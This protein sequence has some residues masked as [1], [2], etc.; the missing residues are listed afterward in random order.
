MKYSK[1]M[2]VALKQLAEALITD[3][4]ADNADV[5]MEEVLDNVDHFF[6]SENVRNTVA[7]LITGE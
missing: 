2:Q 5:E 6:N 3:A 7:E 4:K 1:E